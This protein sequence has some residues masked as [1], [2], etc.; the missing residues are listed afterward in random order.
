MFTIDEIRCSD[1]VKTIFGH[2]SEEM[3]RGIPNSTALSF[4]ID[5]LEKEIELL[6]IIQSSWARAEARHPI[7]EETTQQKGDNNER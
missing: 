4:A 7:M 1:A 2:I 5:E 6:K 3:S